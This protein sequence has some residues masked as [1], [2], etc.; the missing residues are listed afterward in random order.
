MIH[1]DQIQ[2]LLPHEDLNSEIWEDY[3]LNSKIRKALLRI[4]NEFYISLDINVPVADI[5]FTGSLANFNYTKFSDIDL[6]LLIDY[7]T[8]DENYDLVKNYMMAKKSTWN[9]KHDIRIKGYEV[10]LYAQDASE[11][12]H[13]TG[14][15]SVLGDKWITKPTPINT[16]VDFQAIRCKAE[17]LMYEIDQV[18][19]SPNRL[20]KINRIKEKIRSMR[21]S[22]LERAGEFSTEN[23]AF[24]ILRRN[25]YLER[26]YSTATKDFDDS[27]SVKQE[28]LLREY[29]SKKLFQDT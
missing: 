23:L 26:L 20:P 12:H 16:D 24:K 6:H 25:G 7:F 11:P 13:S 15:Y 19:Q 18:L 17:S 21:Q 1:K 4:A 28:S 8:V 5:T 2:S 22:G 14:V 29:I 9:D 3:K 27:L 10:E